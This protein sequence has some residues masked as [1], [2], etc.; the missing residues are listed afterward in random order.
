MTV[1]ALQFAID[2]LTVRQ[3]VT[4]DNLSNT[5][6]P[7]FTAGQVDF[8]SGLQGA[9]AAAVPTAASVSVTPSTAPAN[10]NGNN[11]DMGQELVTAEETTLRY[12]TMVDALNT[13]FRILR[14]SIGGSFQ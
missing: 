4:A 6:T 1:Q 5:D 7:G 8:E 12:Q 13:Q 11:V 10:A 9:L 3:Q 2:G 14:G